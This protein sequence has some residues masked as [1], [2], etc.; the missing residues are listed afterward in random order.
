MTSLSFYCA[1]VT[2]GGGGLGR[3]IAEY[4]LGEGKKVIIV[5]RTEST[6]RQT[7]E[8]IGATDYFVLDT[9]KID[10]ISP[11]IGT[12]LEKYPEIDCLINN[13]GVQRPLRV[14]RDEPAEFLLKA[15]EEIDIN[16]RGPMHLTLGLL[17]HFKG[18]PQGATIINVS[19]ILAFVPFS[20]INPVYNGTKAWLH[21]WSMALRSQLSCGGYENIKVVEVAPPS[22]ATNLHRDREDPDDNKKHKNP[23]VLSVD[24][25][26][27][28]FISGLE[29]EDT[30]IAPGMSQ[31]IVEKWYAEFGP[32]YQTLS[33][34]RP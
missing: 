25:F 30:M 21:F 34:D 8:E 6:L 32:V 19:S 1:I 20:V 10:Q 27:D 16:I 7:A 3:A 12:I 15:D 29:R 11:F 5:G 18:K 14:L 31:E 17:D 28:F 22:V 2:G 13:A 23:S 9:G 33:G 24:E 4:L 26:M